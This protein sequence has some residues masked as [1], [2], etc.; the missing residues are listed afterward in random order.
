MPRIENEKFYK[1]SLE[2]Y[3]FTCEALHWNSEQN[4][5][6]RFKVL[7]SLIKDDISRCRVIDVGCGFGDLYNYM[8]Q[9]PL[10]YIGI[11]IMQ[12]MVEEAKTRT[13]CQILQ[14]DACVDNLP[15][16]DYYLCSG[17]M[18]I[19]SR[20]E[21]YQ[22]IQNCYNASNKGFIFNILEGEDESLVYNYFKVKDIKAIAA[23]LGAKV[24][25][26][27]GYLPRDIT[28]GMYK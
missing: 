5:N 21:T 12:E 6:I 11:D 16:G 26:K 15:F 17:S 2:K 8:K 10:R 1:A 20:F 28:I 13:G 22:F 24:V 4:Q 7:L 23:E 3:G 27:R 19:L 14:L 25:M 18:N 9:K